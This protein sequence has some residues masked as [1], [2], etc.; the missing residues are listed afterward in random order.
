MNVIKNTRKG[1]AAIEY[2]VTYGWVFV[3]IIAAITVLSYFDILTPSNYLPSTCD[4]GQQL[5]CVDQ[6][7]DSDGVVVLRFKNLFDANI[8]VVD[9][10]MFNEIDEQYESV[11]TGP[12]GGSGEEVIIPVNE[13][14]RVAFQLTNLP[15]EGRKERVRM[16]LTFQ[17]QGG[18]INHSLSGTVFGEVS[19]PLSFS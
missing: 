17:R 4:F 15:S 12:I 2:L 11:F 16:I 3:V 14:G 19:E 18:S 9:A 7:I 5:S 10:E 6:Y 13:I 8:T 1:Q